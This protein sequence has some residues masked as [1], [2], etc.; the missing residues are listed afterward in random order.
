[1]ARAVTRSYEQ[2]H[3]PSQV[4]WRVIRVVAL[5]NLKNP[6]RVRLLGFRL[7]GQF[8]HVLSKNPSFC[9]I[10]YS[11][12]SFLQMGA[13]QDA[14]WLRPSFHASL[15]AD[16]SSEI[17]AALASQMRRRLWTTKPT[18]ARCSTTIGHLRLSTRNGMLLAMQ[19]LYKA[20]TTEYHFHAV[21]RKPLAHQWHTI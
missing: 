9:W 11:A 1:M 2:N 18:S 12:G 16:C 20:M 6:F 14:S 10:Y 3:M 17:F 13:R 15:A 4:S 5:K 19:M 21:S 7:F 8:G